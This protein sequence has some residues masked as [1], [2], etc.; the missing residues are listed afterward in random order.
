MSD[1]FE[2]A[3]RCKLRFE[4]TKGLLSSEEVWDL[5]L[6]SL[7]AMA[8]VINRRLREA[9]EE[10]FIPPVHQPR[11]ASHDVLRLEVLKYVILVKVAERDRAKKKAEDHA[12]LVRLREL[13]VAKE[14]EMFR[15]MSEEEIRKQIT[16]LETVP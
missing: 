7:D 12:K 11:A 10:S 1:V 4:T 16:E 8:K 5:S 3:V 14:D 6:T 15:I 9:E 13:L 2:K